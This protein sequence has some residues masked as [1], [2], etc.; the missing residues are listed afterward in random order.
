V[1][2]ALRAGLVGC[3]S[4]SQRGILPHLS[5]PDAR[6]KV[7]L[8]AVADAVAER[9]HENAV[10]FGV[11]SQFG[12]V[13]A[14]L[15][16]V[17]LDLVIVATPVQRHFA[18]A[19]AAVEAGKHVYVQKA[20]TSTLDQANELLAARD[21]AGVKLSAAPG[22]ELCTTTEAMRRVVDDGVIGHVYAAFTY[23]FG[24]MLGRSPQPGQRDPLAEIDPT[25]NFQP[26]GGGPLPSITVYSL[27][28][29]TSLLGPVR[30]V[31][32]LAN[33]HL[34]ERRWAGKT[35]P[36]EIADNTIVLMEFASGALGTAV[37]S[38]GRPTKWTPWGGLSLHGASGSLQVTEVHHA[39]GYPMRFEVQA[40]GQTREVGF[41]LSD[42]PYLSGNHT[43][44]QEPHVYA[45]IMDLVDAV[46]DDRPV[47]APG[48]R[49][50]HVV[51]IIEKAEL[52][53]RS[54]QSQTLTTT[55][56]PVPPRTAGTPVQ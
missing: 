28:L 16:G 38:A 51:E 13:E 24:I 43:A 1:S 44:I 55:F 6:E 18:D 48:E 26:A 21:R 49:A 27:Q 42:Q 5:E 4:L 17:E 50:R 22:Y 10:R 46:R 35:I 32:A 53:A 52:A 12:G 9:A 2:Q 23:T 37:G 20:M 19:L 47:R 8:V 25:W 11:P 15:A 30:R 7:R 45:D 14:M 56:A 41:E 31:T 3:G 40:G 54:G 29:A 39:S 36:V 33:H 34:E